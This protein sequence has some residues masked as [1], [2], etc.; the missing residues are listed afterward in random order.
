MTQ[1]PTDALRL[2]PPHKA[3]TLAATLIEMAIED[4]RA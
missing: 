4:M 3:R 1:T 2:V